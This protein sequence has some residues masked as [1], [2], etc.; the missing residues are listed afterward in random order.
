MLLCE[1]AFKLFVVIGWKDVELL[2]PFEGKFLVLRAKSAN[3]SCYSY[4][5]VCLSRV[6]DVCCNRFYVSFLI[7]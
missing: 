3:Y 4:W 7:L 6:V 2:R 1:T 5:L